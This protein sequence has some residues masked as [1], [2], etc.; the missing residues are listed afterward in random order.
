[1]RSGISVAEARRIVLAEVETLPAET[2][3]THEALERVL[4]EA[5]AARFTHP[6]ADS[7]AMD[8]YAVCTADLAA[9]GADH[10]VRLPQAFEV[11]AGAVAPRALRSGEVARI[12]TGAPLP[13]GADAVV[14]QEDTLREDDAVSFH[15]APAAGDHVRAAGEDVSAGETVLAQGT[16][17]RSAQLGMLAALGRTLVRVHRRPRVALI[18]G[19]DELVEPDRAG[20]DGRIISS[21][22]YALAAECRSLGVE[23]W[24]LGIAEDSRE[25]LT[26]AV[27]SGLSADVVVSTAGVSVGDHDHVRP[28][29]EALGCELSFW[30]V[31]MK[32][33]FPVVF[34]RFPGGPL[35]FGLPGNPVSALVTFLQFVAPALRKAQGQRRLL[36]PTIRAQLGETLTKAAGRTH[37]VRVVLTEEGGGYVARSTGNQSSGVL[38]S[39]ALADGLLDFPADATELRAGEEVCV[40][41]LDPMRLGVAEAALS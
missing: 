21:N 23:V 2:I 38:R 34:G 11:A 36:P 16:L 7:S 26:N 40:Q 6:P 41:L 19:G 9:A 31:L 22:A 12:F 13:P 24:N 18:S 1:M 29:L 33:G 15:V 4:A 5:V 39:L 37:F 3:S 35:V 20:D 28:V 30:G 32:P 17:L 14:R 8:G 25:A 10:P 27:R